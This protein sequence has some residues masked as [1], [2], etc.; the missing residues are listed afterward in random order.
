MAFLCLFDFIILFFCLW[1]V[2][3]IVIETIQE[4]RTR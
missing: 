2:V 1:R 3:E 4:N